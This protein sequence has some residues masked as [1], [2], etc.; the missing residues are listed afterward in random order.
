[1]AKYTK[2]D[3]TPWGTKDPF[4]TKPGE[5]K[6]AIPTKAEPAPP[7]ILKQKPTKAAATGYKAT[8]MEDIGKMV[9]D[10]GEW[11]QGQEL[12]FTNRPELLAEGGWILPEGFRQAEMGEEP[13]DLRQ[14]LPEGSYSYA[15]MA[16]LYPEM[17]EDPRLAPLQQELEAQEGRLKALGVDATRPA[18]TQEVINNVKAQYVEEDFEQELISRMGVDPYKMNPMGELNYRWK[19]AQRDLFKQVFQGAIDWSD[20]TRM[21]KDEREYWN[22][23]QR[24]WK[25][26]TYNQLNNM[27]TAK[28]Q[29]YENA[30]GNFHSRKKTHLA[31]LEKEQGAQEKASKMPEYMKLPNKK[32][33][34]TLHFWDKSKRAL[35]DTGRVA[36]LDDSDL[37]PKLK[38]MMTMYRT[39]KGDT[40]TNE[41]AQMLVATNPEMADNTVIQAMMGGDQSPE[42]KAALSHIEKLAMA[43]VNKLAGTVQPVEAPKKVEPKAKGAA[44]PRVGAP[45]K[46]REVPQKEGE[47][48]PIYSYSDTSEYET[49]DV[50]EFKGTKGNFHVVKA[51]G[52]IESFDDEAAA[53]AFVITLKE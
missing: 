4:A 33:Q 2:L 13:I 17:F 31:A 1:M 18:V 32:G 53:V 49:G 24:Q 3:P 12:K 28:I 6:P 7:K 39:F 5:Q 45:E 41:M 48:I 36:K 46:I 35:V 19:T 50:I 42:T 30:M 52:S 43:Y 27:R 40:R 47:A 8:S 21:N 14:M 44:P 37:P 10:P 25:A 23:A 38:Q 26:D 29:E 22:T 51:D 15:V 20:R 34:V 11:E 9:R 16:T